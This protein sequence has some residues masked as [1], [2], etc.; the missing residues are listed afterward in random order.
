MRPGHDKER[1]SGG[2]VGNRK[3]SYFQEAVGS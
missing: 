2:A 1:L 3:K